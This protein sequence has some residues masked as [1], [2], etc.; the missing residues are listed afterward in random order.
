MPSIGCPQNSLPPI[1]FRQGDANHRYPRSE[2][3]RRIDLKNKKTHRWVEDITF[4]KEPQPSNTQSS[5]RHR[6]I[7]H[8]LADP[9]ST[10]P[11]LPE[12]EK[13]NLDQPDESSPGEVE[14]EG[15]VPNKHVSWTSTPTKN[16]LGP[17]RELQIPG[18]G[19]Q[20]RPDKPTGLTLDAQLCSQ[21]PQRFN[22]DINS[23]V[24]H[25]IKY[26]PSPVTDPK[27]IKRR[28]QI[29]GV[30]LVLSKSCR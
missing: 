16:H 22:V 2:G 14:K 20:T 30:F 7:N 18:D 27:R 23:H 21:R 19:H 3:S 25:P 9:P 29:I 24:D 6:G 11:D 13:V 8:P 17:I 4:W 12:D 1:P 26:G 10:N 28:Q 5:T 15:L